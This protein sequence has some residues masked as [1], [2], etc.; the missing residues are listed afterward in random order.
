MHGLYYIMYTAII[1]VAYLG[2]CHG[3]GPENFHS[4]YL[5]GAFPHPPQLLFIKLS[6]LNKFTIILC[7]NLIYYDELTYIHFDV[8]YLFLIIYLTHLYYKF[9]FSRT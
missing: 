7:K 5:W 9:Q 1:S 2:I 3:K 4:T 6:F 8:N